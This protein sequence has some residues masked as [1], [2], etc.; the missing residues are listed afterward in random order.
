M[1]PT[2]APAPRLRRRPHHRPRPR[3]PP[4]DTLHARALPHHRQPLDPHRK[5]PAT[6]PS[7]PQWPTD[8]PR[9]PLRRGAVVALRG[10]DALAWWHRRATQAG[11]APD[12][13]TMEPRNFRRPRS[14]GPGPFHRLVQFDGTALITDPQSLATALVNGIGRGQ[15]YGAGLLSLAPA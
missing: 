7:R 2:R 10:P 4:P 12:T 15:S 8:H 5:E 14:A 6:P 3:H 13:T 11:L 9:H 1:T